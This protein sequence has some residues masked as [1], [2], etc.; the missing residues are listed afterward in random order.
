MGCWLG[1]KKMAVSSM[2]GLLQRRSGVDAQT[3]T[4]PAAA[5]VRRP[6]ATGVRRAGSPRMASGWAGSAASAA[7]SLLKPL[8]LAYVAVCGAV[9]VFQR[10]LQ[11]FPSKAHPPVP[12]VHHDLFRDV[13]EVELQS[14]DGT[15]CF[16]WHW[17]APPARAPVAPFFW[18]RAPGIGGYTEPELRRT[19]TD[20][21]VR[22]PRLGSV[23]VLLLHGNAGDRSHR[24]GWMH[25]LREG[26]GVSVTVLD[27]RGYGGSDG[28][29]T[30]AGLIADGLAATKWLRAKRAR[31]GAA[32][33][34]RFH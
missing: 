26:L 34:I 11:Y 18:L 28:T 7:L 29:P 6:I 13:Q 16:A 24:L 3:A 25:L 17:P 21:R 15:R 10:Q 32:G 23:D 14:A 1:D 8:G 2:S 12:G 33:G 22:Y 20:L 27:Y 5:G 30:E 19:C 31:E 9:Y 4:T